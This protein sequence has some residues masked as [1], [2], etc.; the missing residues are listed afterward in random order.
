MATDS[1]FKETESSSEEPGDEASPHPTPN[2]MRP[3]RPVRRKG[4]GRI[5][6]PVPFNRPGLDLDGEPADSDFDS[7]AAPGVNIENEHD[8]P[9]IPLMA[10]RA[11][12]TSVRPEESFADLDA[13]LFDRAPAAPISDRAPPAPISDRAPPAPL[14]EHAP[15]VPVAERARRAPVV[16]RA[17]RP[18]SDRAPSAS[19]SDHAPPAPFSDRAPPAPFSDRAP[20]APVTPRGGR[21]ASRDAA[22][23][24]PPRAIPFASLRAER[25]QDE[26]EPTIVGRVPDNLLELSGGG[27]ETR[28]FTAPRELIELARR[29]REERRESK[30]PKDMDA[31]VTER[32]P[33][34][35]E[36]E[37]QAA[38]A[39]LVESGRPRAPQEDSDAAP[40]VARTVSGE[41]EAV[42]LPSRRT[43]ESEPPESDAPTSF[44]SELSG[45]SIEIGPGSEQSDG[46]GLSANA[47]SDPRSE[48]LPS[49]VT[50]SAPRRLW[51]WVA[52]FVLVGIVIARWRDIALLLHR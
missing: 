48:P 7:D 5:P 45:P 33:A 11:K 34:P 28:A 35:Q 29:K 1:T 14:S 21:A 2:P 32:P 43:P 6:L 52:L 24:T 39:V 8:E 17:A 9:A 46:T 49:T 44:P 40:P 50:T 51:I 18:A 37:G 23:A 10:A 26:H 12:P 42:A 16:E 47:S 4:S 38:P 15:R 36:A 31:R 25:Q 30:A 22:E 41:M 27:D 20:A 19:I 3:P 13:D